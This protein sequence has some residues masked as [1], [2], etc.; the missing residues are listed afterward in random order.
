[1]IDKTDKWLLDY[2]RKIT[3]Q[4]G[5]DGIIEKIFEVIGEKNKW[6]VE[7]GALNGVHDS[8][9][10]NLLNHRG[11]SGVLIEADI[12]NYKKLETLY[13]PR[14]D[15][16][17]INEFVSFEGNHSL[18]AIF[19]NT[20]IPREFDL[21]SLD[22]DG[23]EYHLWK[24]LVTY[25][26]R[27]MIV[28]FNPS[29]PNDIDFVQPRDMNVFQ[30]SS[31][32]A[33]VK[34]GKQKG[35]ELISVVGVNAI[36]VKK[37]LFPLFEIKDNSPEMLYTDKSAYTRLFQLYDG[38]LVLS[39]CDMLLWHKKKIRAEDI[40]IVPRGKRYYPAKIN[41]S[42]FIRSVKEIVRRLPFYSLLLRFRNWR[43]YG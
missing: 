21:L 9:V 28:E 6:C 8:N 13:R 30:G 1:M 27:A 23:N 32:L 15:I 18:D 41:K 29:I 12:T 2:H 38:T 17:C 20:Q 5:E 4:F 37:E 25:S 31:L 33:L 40:Q 39:G 14:E 22:I 26:P 3:S 43:F 11:W 24:S 16:A 19:A 34:L 42:K 7:L 10:W 36:F 35:Y